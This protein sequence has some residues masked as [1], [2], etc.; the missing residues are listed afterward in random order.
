[1]A[2]TA[3]CLSTAAATLLLTSQASALPNQIDSTFAA[4]DGIAEPIGTD[5]GIVTDIA[6][7]PGGNGGVFVAGNFTSPNANTPNGHIWVAALHHNGQPKATFG[8]EGLRTFGP[9]PEDPVEYRDPHLERDP[10][11][12]N[13]F[14]SWSQVDGGSTQ[15]AVERWNRLNG[16]RDTTF[17]GGTGRRTVGIPLNLAV[18]SARLTGLA[19]NSAGSEILVAGYT[20]PATPVTVSRAIVVKLTGASATPDAVFDPSPDPGVSLF[21][22]DSERTRVNDVSADPAGRPILAIDADTPGPAAGERALVARLAL[23]GELDA[24]FGGSPAPGL[25]ELVFTQGVTVL[26]ARATALELNDDGSIAVVGEVDGTGE[27]VAPMIAKISAGGALVNGF[28]D[29]SLPGRRLL[30]LPDGAFGLTGLTNVLGD[31]YLGAGYAIDGG[32]TAATA[33][34]LTSTGAPDTSFDPVSPDL[35][36]E[37]V[38]AF[39]PTVAGR[40][41]VVENQVETGQPVM[42]TTEY[43]PLDHFPR[44]FRLGKEAAPPTGLSATVK[45][46]SAP[47]DTPIRPGSTVELTGSASNPDGPDAALTFKWKGL[48]GAVSEKTGKTIETTFPFAPAGEP[49]TVTMIVTAPTGAQAT[50]EVVV[51]VLANQP[52]T[53][54]RLEVGGFTAAQPVQVDLGATLSLTGVGSDPEEGS[55]TFWTFDT[56]DDGTVGPFEGT[57][58]DGTKDFV[59]SKPGSI[60]YAAAANDSEGGVSNTVTRKVSVEAA[61]ALSEQTGGKVNVGKLQ[62]HADCI[63]RV[64]K[65]YSAGANKG[66]VAKRTYFV[67][68]KGTVNGLEIEP[69]GKTTYFKVTDFPTTNDPT[70]LTAGSATVATRIETGGELIEIADGKLSWKL[71]GTDLNGLSPKTV[72]LDGIKL[73]FKGKPQVPGTPNVINLV[74]NLKL[75]PSLGGSNATKAATFKA[76]GSVF[77]KFDVPGASMFGDLDFANLKF[78]RVTDGFYAKASMSLPGSKGSFGVSGELAIING[79]F[80]YG[81]ADVGFGSPGIPAGPTFFIQRIG[82]QVEA[83]QVDA[84]GA[85]IYQPTA[86]CVDHVGQKTISVL[87]YVEDGD[88]VLEDWEKLLISIYQS[89]EVF[90]VHYDY[91]VPTLAVC[92]DFDFTFGPKVLGFALATGTVSVGAAFYPDRSDVLRIKGNVNVIG[93]PVTLL[94]EIYSNGY[95]MIDVKGKL[96]FEDVASLQ[97]HVNFEAKFPKFNAYGAV[98][99][100]LYIPW[101]MCAGAEGL[102]SSKGVAACLRIGG[103][104]PGAS[105]VYGEFPTPYVW[106]CEV[107]DVRVQIAGGSNTYVTYLDGNGNPVGNTFSAAAAGGRESGGGGGGVAHAS[108]DPARAVGSETFVVEPGTP[109]VIVSGPGTDGLPHFVL[110][111]PDGRIVD[112]DP[113][114]APPEDPE[115]DFRDLSG[116]DNVTVVDRE[117]DIT[118]AMVADP[119]PGTWTMR[120]IEGSSP[121]L[122]PVIAVGDSAPTVTGTVRGTGQNRAVD[123]KIEERPGLTVSLYESGA[124]GGQ[125][126]RT[127]NAD[128]PRGQER[129]LSTRRN[130]STPVR[131]GYTG[132]ETF[133]RVSKDFTPFPGLREQRTITAYITD[134]EG[135]PVDIVEVD[136]YTSP[137]ARRPDR[138][139]GLDLNR[140]PSGLR[141]DW[142]DVAG[143][144]HYRVEVTLPDGREYLYFPTGSGLKL[145]VVANQ[146]GTVEVKV[147]TR[148]IFG[149]SSKGAASDRLGLGRG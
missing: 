43:D 20:Q 79:Q 87:E 71:K 133:T 72:N 106:G 119:A 146:R 81:R 63:D 94:S 101:T 141:A 50:R 111:G 127:I 91:G 137:K 100:C 53:A 132:K 96:E 51:E 44:V 118:H 148:D 16:N 110:E 117:R 57:D 23:T 131:V 89:F 74:A 3:A 80:A 48:S 76:G 28:G 90:Q 46:V 35:G 2:A 102:L 12:G 67:T 128:L 17:A 122:D 103:W 40:E 8:S 5:P 135:L 125:L 142:A 7:I 75:P 60:T 32:E 86:S 92:G 54:A 19:T 11:T 15:W 1:M 52:P 149:I 109:G 124:S 120:A 140:T 33:M 25:R 26:S 30:T 121:I 36:F 45:K 29:P 93:I 116:A 70:T 55:P 41:A 98:K 62:I 138:P 84:S 77:P 145:P 18:E 34:R 108:A 65:K 58:F 112:A 83:P 42:A 59:A 13:L 147:Q 130:S 14:V 136:T 82:V 126:L 24:A 22:I 78:E 66:K 39:Q 9:T 37:H 56:N 97:G 69:T 88:G 4:P 104:K 10:A 115:T 21:R 68:G 123:V 95:V 143:S 27:G 61:C 134:D 107:D 85:P 6:T 144:D 47:L 129:V 49:W 64:I 38:A 139:S 99:A 113:E 114:T 105:W 73:D 31:R